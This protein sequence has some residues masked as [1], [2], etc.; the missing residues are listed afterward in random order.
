MSTLQRYEIRAIRNFAE[1][2]VPPDAWTRPLLE[3]P[4]PQQREQLRGLKV[5]AQAYG[6]REAVANWCARGGR[7]GALR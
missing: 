6:S 5:P 2:G 7:E 1:L 4:T 3:N